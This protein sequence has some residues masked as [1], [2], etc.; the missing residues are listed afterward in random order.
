ME[1]VRKKKKLPRGPVDNP[2]ENPPPCGKAVEN[3]RVSVE[4]PWLGPVETVEKHLL[5]QV[6]IS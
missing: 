6:L 5:R 3:P 4:F 2:V 1:T